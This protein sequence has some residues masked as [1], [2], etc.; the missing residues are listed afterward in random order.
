MAYDPA[1]FCEFDWKAQ[2][3]DFLPELPGTYPEFAFLSLPAFR[4]LAESLALESADLCLPILAHFVARHGQRLWQIDTGGDSCEIA[5]VPPEQTSA[6][7]A[8]WADAEYATL[9]PVKPA[10]PPKRKRAAKLAWFVDRHQFPGRLSLR[11]FQYFDGIGT[12]MEEVYDDTGGSRDW[13][14]FAFDCNR[15]PPALQD[16]SRLRPGIAAD[17]LH[18]VGVDGSKRCWLRMLPRASD[19]A[20][21]ATQYELSEGDVFAPF[22]PEI[23][24]AWDYRCVVASGV[25]YGVHRRQLQGDESTIYAVLR[26]DAESVTEIFSHARKPELLL[27]GPGRLMIVLENQGRYSRVREPGHYWLWDEG[28]PVP[29]SGPLPFPADPVHTG[30]ALAWLGGDEILFCSTV[31]KPPPPPLSEDEQTLVLH[32]F[33]LVT[34]THRLALL[35]GLG[36]VTKINLSMLKSQ[37]ENIVTLSGFEGSID[38]DKGGGG[39]WI[40]NYS[41]ARHGKRTICW[42]WNQDS[43]EVIKLTSE[44]IRGLDVRGVVY[45]PGTGS[46]LLTAYNEVYRMAELDRL[47]DDRRDGTLTWT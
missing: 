28:A 35:E 38:I 15:W 24:C 25:I 39:W 42:F 1:T 22:G 17:D 40:L 6:F 10:A 16:I 41:P 20:G 4:E 37:P 27:L 9:M 33:D 44:E 30:T 18:L 11:P 5:I 19:G 3:K 26:V 2:G 8:C 31:G 13:A 34:G 29:M 14:L 46:Y 32:R 36:S 21:E 47:K 12:E 43:N 45:S 23:D 7:E